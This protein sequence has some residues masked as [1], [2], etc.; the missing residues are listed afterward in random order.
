MHENRKG[1]LLISAIFVV[2][3][4]ASLFFI[5]R[6]VVTADD[7]NELDTLEQKAKN[8]QRMIDLKQQQQ[9]TLKNQMK[10]MNLQISNFN[11]DILNIEKEIKENK[12][13]AKVIQEDIDK[14]AQEIEDTKDKLQE[15]LV[16]FHQ[17]DEE[18]S[19]ELL[20]NKGDISVILNQS[21]YLDQTSQEVEKILD[22]IKDKKVE[23]EEKRRELQGKND[24]LRR[25]EGSLREKIYDLDNEKETKNVLLEKTRGEEAKYQQLLARVEAQ[26]M[27]LI[28]YSSI[29][30]DVQKKID[31]ILK[32]AKKPKKSK[33]ASTDWYY[34]QKDPRWG[35]KR[36][37]LSSTLMQNYGC[38][39]TALAMVFTYHDEDIKPGKLA[40]KPIFYQDLIVWPKEWEDLNLI[41]STAHAGV[42]WDIIDT[43]IKHK[44][45]VIVFVR[46]FDGKGHYVVIQGKYKDKYIV[47]DPLFGDN[48]YLDTTK[49]LVSTIYGGA[50]VTIDQMIIYH[51]DE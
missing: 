8:Y 16:L 4:F 45:P 43:E 7:D 24:E 41:S 49:E 19:M 46:A 25:K 17:I 32:K 47:H 13:Q 15:V 51:D 10:M 2:A 26:K 12:N 50:S 23:L 5:N 36:I 27:E 1:K 40:G 38:A 37:G 44:N 48:L 28:G 3:F 9:T 31:K 39:V 29:S 21:E 20:L 22:E 42:D 6:E 33:R 34:S 35:A 30:G 14:T 11:T 18:F